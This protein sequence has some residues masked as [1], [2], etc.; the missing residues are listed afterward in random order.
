MQKIRY[1]LTLLVIFGFIQIFAL[2]I[3]AKQTV[4]QSPYVS[5]S[6]DGLAWTTNAGDK[7]WEY[8]PNGTVVSTGIQSSL[9]ALQPGEHYY[10][11]NCVGEIPVGNWKVR[12]SP[13]RCIHSA[14]PPFGVSYHGISFERKICR[15][16]Y[17]SGWIP[18]CA[19]C[20][21]EISILFYMSR[22]AAE[23]IDYLPGG[24]EYYYL[25]P[26]C[27]NLEQ[28]RPVS[29]TCKG[30][31]KN[32]YRVRYHPGEIGVVGHMTDDLFL[33][34]NATSFEGQEMHPATS[35]SR[36]T[37]QLEGYVFDSWN[38]SPD[39]TGQS[40]PDG[41]EVINLTTENWRKGGG[42][43]GV[44]TLY[45]QWRASSSTLILKLQGG[46]YKGK[47]DTYTLVG[48]YGQK[49]AIDRTEVS[50]PA[51]NRVTFVTNGGNQLAPIVGKQSFQ[52]WKMQQ[53]FG[54]LYRDNCYFFRAPAGNVDT[55]EAV[56]QREPIALP[57]VTRPEYAFG[58]WFYDEE[59][60]KP[61]GA[62]GSFI[63]PMKDLTLYAQWVDLVLTSKDNYQ[64]HSGKGAVDLSWTTEKGSNY[65]YRL[66][67]GRTISNFTQLLQTE[68]LNDVKTVQLD[69]K[70]ANN[71]QKLTVPSTGLYYLEALGA[72]G[73]NYGENS[74]GKGG[75]VSADFWLSEGE[76]IMV[77]VGAQDGTGL[78]GAK[79]KDGYSNGGGR[80]VVE[81]S[82]QGT[83]LIAGGGGGAGLLENGRPGGSVTGLRTEHSG[84]GESGMAGGGAGQTGGTAGEIVYHI[85]GDKCSY[86]THGE[87][88]Y[89]KH[90]HNENC[91]KD[92]TEIIGSSPSYH[93][94]C[95]CSIQYFYVTCHYCKSNWTTTVYNSVP[96]VEGHYDN[97]CRNLGTKEC[98]S[99]VLI[100]DLS[101][102]PFLICPLSEGYACGKAE[103][104]S[105]DSAKP[106]YGG[107]NYI[108]DVALN[109]WSNEAGVQAEDGRA[110]ILS[111]Q[112][113]YQNTSFLDGVEAPDLEK[114]DCIELASVERR[115][116]EEQS[117]K[118]TWQQP[119]D[120]GTVYYH[121]AESWL[122][123]GKQPVCISNVTENRLVSGIKG[124][125]YVVNEEP[126]MQVTEE[127]GSFLS[128]AEYTDTFLPENL[129]KSRYLHL[130]AVDV[131]GNIGDSIPISLSYRDTDVGELFWRMKTEQVFVMESSH[132]H[133]RKDNQWFVKADGT[134]QL[135]LSASGQMLGLPR[136]DYQPNYLMLV[137][138]MEDG[139]QK[140]GI[141]VSKGAVNLQP[142]ELQGPEFQ[143]FSDGKFPLER[144]GYTKA[145]RTSG[146][147]G[148]EYTQGFVVPEALHGKQIVLIPRIGADTAE[149]ILWS[150]LGQ[151]RQNGIVLVGDGE[152]PVISGTQG[153][154]A[155]AIEQLLSGT[156]TVNLRATDELSGVRE[157]KVTV[158]N[159]NNG[160]LSY[161]YPESDGGIR[162]HADTSQPLWDS[163]VVITVQAV[164]QVGNETTLEYRSNVLA[165]EAS[166]QRILEP[167]EPIFQA[168]E[169]GKLTFRALGYADSVE[170]VFPGVLEDYRPGLAQVY[171]YAG[172]KEAEKKEE[173]E[174]MVPLSTPPGS[175]AVTV[176]ARKGERQ[177]TKQ[178]S[179]QVTD[180]GGGLLSELRTRLR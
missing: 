122:P 146:C 8:I 99:N 16:N 96:C 26:L 116:L 55:L 111:K 22:Q 67:Q 82:L 60:Q 139:D 56:Y 9:R 27:N 10:D 32:R 58:G 125:L 86:H 153:L 41:A 40:F 112:I 68:K 89:E 48:E 178:L 179:F 12:Y 2:P 66:Y 124:Y 175:Y 163:D 114:P 79:S 76:V 18:T 158:Y 52:E 94:D 64:V 121:R 21:E 5:L 141:S 20:G 30:I 171:D 157:W 164:D 74:G 144:T 35:L 4:Y 17:Y 88:C 165:L 57:A 138:E 11:K 104:I 107:S 91:Y 75:L 100:C 140:L 28:G 101:E 150:D 129:E 19:D 102:K 42:D 127:N 156:K 126:F 103:G 24:S 61:A 172:S 162:L 71:G 151:D 134:T 14:Y 145:V 46:S 50:P 31:S 97:T 77:S 53:P 180:E 80:T 161:F 36:N 38:T 155:E 23:S 173:I 131:A 118:I 133:Y 177:V 1:L 113:G 43:V 108:S 73:G 87:S 135:L 44:V 70:M 132:V 130:A 115:V 15:G 159:P 154:K 168:G 7:N 69:W 136:A 6:P 83:L 65:F 149:E 59:F 110:S 34:D 33:Y 78:G 85:H 169:S 84:A 170:V 166:L 93:L 92:Y 117:I 148:L 95:G 62:A 174:F 72:Q 81:S 49:E 142:V 137:Q 123:G 119:L 47:K 152:G 147:L 128:T 37:Y 106:G 51:G 160:C 45:A 120:R 167:H 90:E 29:H 54:G 176:T 109:I 39:G 63:T 3:Q 25:C 98:H 105:I 143:R 13:G